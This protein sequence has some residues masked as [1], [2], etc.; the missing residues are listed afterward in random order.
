MSWS[1]SSCLTSIQLALVIVTADLGG[2]ANQI[3]TVDVPVA[4]EEAV[5]VCGLAKVVDS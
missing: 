2:G 5:Q 4:T 1:T 3:T